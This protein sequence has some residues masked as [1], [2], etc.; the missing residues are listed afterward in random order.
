MRVWEIAKVYIADLLRLF[1]GYDVEISNTAIL[2]T[3]IVI[4]LI[5]VAIWSDILFYK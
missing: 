3:I 4:A 5:V 2:A 1:F